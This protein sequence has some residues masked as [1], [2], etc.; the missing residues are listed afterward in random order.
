M[1]VQHSVYSKETHRFWL[2]VIV[3]AILTVLKILPEAAVSES[4]KPVL[5]RDSV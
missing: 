5:G 3:L 2:Q 4:D 1:F